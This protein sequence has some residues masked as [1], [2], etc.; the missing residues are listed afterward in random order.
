[1][2]YNSDTAVWAG[3][4]PLQ[5]QQDNTSGLEE[6]FSGIPQPKGVGASPT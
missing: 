3:E 1:M 5:N 4:Q 2:Q 6:G